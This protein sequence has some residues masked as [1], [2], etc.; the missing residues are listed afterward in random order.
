MLTS[1]KDYVG[2]Q[3]LSFR[4]KHSYHRNMTSLLPLSAQESLILP[5]GA[6]KLLLHCCCAPCSGGVIKLLQANGCSLTVYFYN[7]NIHPRD[8][9]VLRKQELMRFCDKLHVAFVDADYDT[10]NWFA[11]IKGLEAE[12]EGSKRCT[13]CFSLRLERTA[14]F[15]KEKGFA[16][17]ATTMGISRWKN[18]DQ[19]NQCGLQAATQHENIRFWD[20]NWRQRGGSDRML[21]VA[22]EEAFYQQEYCGCTFSLAASNARRREAGRE[23]IKPGT[24]HYGTDAP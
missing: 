4:A 22:K 16:L 2:L 12:R 1:N 11:R 23:D 14:L 20:Y 5:G 18:M 13:Q 17:F 10:E 8:E 21:D 19:V 7:P 9:Y 3:P 24:K 6:Q 15:A